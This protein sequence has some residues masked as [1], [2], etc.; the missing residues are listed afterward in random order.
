M[1]VMSVSASCANNT[2]NNN[3]EEGKDNVDY[4]N[5]HDLFAKVIFL[6]CSYLLNSKPYR[7]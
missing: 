3:E 4:F 7:A 6:R 5:L 2:N 1:K